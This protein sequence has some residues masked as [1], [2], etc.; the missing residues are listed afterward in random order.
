MKVQGRLNTEP[1]A[2]KQNVDRPRVGSDSRQPS[3]RRRSAIVP[4]GAA[5]LVRVV[6]P[7]GTAIS[8]AR[9]QRAHV[10]TGPPPLDDRQ[11]RQAGPSYKSL[12][13]R[14]TSI[15]P[16]V[17]DERAS[18]IV[19]LARAKLRRGTSNNLCTAPYTN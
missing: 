7:P 16:F 4:A 9:E 15:T 2:K 11:P 18:E 10:T 8:G 13:Y 6:L 19:S 12:L 3:P 5:Q 17:G 14:N 1:M